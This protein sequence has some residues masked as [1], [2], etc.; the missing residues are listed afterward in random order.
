MDRWVV[1]TAAVPRPRPPAA[2][3]RPLVQARIQDMRRVSPVDTVKAAVEAL[4]LGDEGQPAQLLRLLAAV[5]AH[6]MSLDL[7]EETG[8]GVV[9][10]RLRRHGAPEVAARA[11][12]LYTRWRAEAKAAQLRKL[13]R[14]SSGGGGGG[15]GG[16][17]AAGAKRP[18][19]ASAREPIDGDGDAARDAARD[20]ILAPEDDIEAEINEWQEASATAAVAAAGA[21]A[22]APHAQPRRRRSA[23]AAAGAASGAGAAA[24]SVSMSASRS[25]RSNDGSDDDAAAHMEL[26]AAARR[27]PPLAAAAAAAPPLVVVASPVAPPRAAQQPP[28]PRRSS[29]GG[30]SFLPVSAIIAP[31]GGVAAGPLRLLPAA[32]ARPTGYR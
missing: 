22:A 17:P 30:L 20:F 4:R 13:K 19:G 23:P 10:N 16:A 31:G 25:S 7:L 2:D 12:A 14:Q 29:G 28:P 8:A 9:V 24:V 32:A 27:R 15:G 18:R 3:A 6:F 26:G 21:R 5:D 1:T 11:E